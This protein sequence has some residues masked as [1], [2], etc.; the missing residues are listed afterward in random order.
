M[1]DQTQTWLQILEATGLAVEWSMTEQISSAT[2]VMMMGSGM[3]ESA[4]ARIYTA[5]STA[6]TSSQLQYMDHRRIKRH[7]LLLCVVSCH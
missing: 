7:A 4:C 3:T 5:Y 1:V 6:R 2:S